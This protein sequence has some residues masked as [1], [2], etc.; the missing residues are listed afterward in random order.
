MIKFNNKGHLIPNLNIPCSLEEFKKTFMEEIPTPKRKEL[1]QKFEDY[2]SSLFEVIKTD[3]KLI[4]WVNG[5]FTTKVDAPNDLD[6]VVFLPFDLIEKHETE[7][8]RLKYPKS[9]EN[10]EVD[11]Y[12]VK[13][14]PQENLKYPLYEGDRLYWMEHFSKTKVNRRGTK[15]PK[16]FLEITLGQID[17]K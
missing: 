8:I 4:I 15:F 2:L 3:Q 10:F 1:H 9:L 5:S 7:L 6:L 14:Y 16:G 11:A 17:Y 12:L 13:T